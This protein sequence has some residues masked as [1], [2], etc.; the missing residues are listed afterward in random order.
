MAAGNS[1][2]YEFLPGFILGFHGTK[3]DV[4]ERVLAGQDLLKKSANDLD[5]LG[6]GIH[7]WESSPIRAYEFALESFARHKQIYQGEVGVVGAI[8]D[9]GKCLN[10]L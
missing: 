5:W 2:L 4:A 10:L 9:P 1:S 8:I 7:F 6:S 3:K